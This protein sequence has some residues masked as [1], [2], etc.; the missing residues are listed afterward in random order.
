LYY[1]FKKEINKINGGNKMTRLK[2]LIVLGTAVLALGATTITAF[3]SADYQNPAEII[4]GLTGKSVDEIVEIRSTTEKTYGTIANDEGKLQ[5]F[6]NEMLENKKALL[7]QRVKDG[8][9][10]Q[11]EADEIYNTI[12]EN[13][14]NC[15]GSGN[16]GSGKRMGA[17]FGK[18][19]GNGNGQG[20]G[21]GQCNGFG[22]GSNLNLQT[23]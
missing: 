23:N 6:K 1:L 14:V 7:D 22:N 10:T 11:A 16:N 13:Q 19:M 18:M 9:L 2:K 20:F 5:E 3:A 12:K 17:G 21:R 4:A 15:D 8:T